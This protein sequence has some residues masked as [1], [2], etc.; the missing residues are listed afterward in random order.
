MWIED[1]TKRNSK[2]KVYTDSVD[3][4]KHRVIEGVADQHYSDGTF[5]VDID[6]SIVDGT[7]SGFAHKCDKVRHAIHIGE[8][9]TRR[10]MPRRNY[11]TEYIEFGR[12]QSWTGAAW[13]DVNLGTAV[14]TGNAIAWDTTNFSLALTNNWH[15]IKI[16]AVLKTEV[17]RR[18][19]RWP[20]SLSG[21]TY[22]AGALTSIA[23]GVVVGHVDKPIAWDAN[24][25]NQNRNVTIV[26]TYSGGYLEFGGDLS[27]VVLPITIDPTFTDGPGGDVTSSFDSYVN[28]AGPDS[29]YGA[30]TLL[31]LWRQGGANR[32]NSLVKFDFSG[33]PGGVTIN[34]RTLY[35]Y[36]YINGALASAN[37]PIYRILVADSGWLENCSWNYANGDI[38][39]D[40]WAG[41]VANN[42]GSDAGCSVSGTDYAAA[43]MATFSIGGGDLLGVEY[44]IS[45]DATEFASMLAAN[46]GLYVIEPNDVECAVCSSD[47]ATAGYRPKI[48]ID[49]TAAGGG[50]DFRWA[51]SNMIWVFTQP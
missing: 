40:R 12:L 35:F 38:A 16:E 25:S 18:R 19:L 43:A 33:I 30:A 51:G 6:E 1:T 32:L 39:T 47:H 24:G 27:L 21:L 2:V 9:G 8:T 20:V 17:A 50:Q 11:P 14:R 5:W 10:W 45:L 23:D 13:V 29:M 37:I 22:N 36:Q 42:G 46:H 28:E 44:A 49:Y 15:R 3:P 41:D 48:V 34:A 31:Y 4:A 7:V 26:T